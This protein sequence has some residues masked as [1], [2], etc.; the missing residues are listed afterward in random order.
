MAVTNPVKYCMCAFSWIIC[1]SLFFKNTHTYRHTHIQATV[2]PT[3]LLFQRSGVKLLPLTPLLEN[4]SE[5][6]KVRF[7][8]CLSLHKVLFHSSPKELALLVG[9]ETVGAGWF[10]SGAAGPA[11]N[12]VNNGCEASTKPWYN[13]VRGLTSWSS[14]GNGNKTQGTL[15]EEALCS[16][17]C[18]YFLALL[19]YLR[20]GT[21]V[22][23]PNN[24]CQ[25]SHVMCL[26]AT[27][28]AS[29]VYPRIKSSLCS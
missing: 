28:W 4:R 3:E 7:G 19:V 18:R 20:T 29:S 25:I 22:F 8:G 14:G 11:E 17:G 2:T 12:K 6:I 9:S 16:F 27:G 24:F 21:L 26:L 13:P 10:C 1:H 15:Q 23:G 5:L